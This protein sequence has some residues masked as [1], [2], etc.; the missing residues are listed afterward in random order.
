VC[1]AALGGSRP[2]SM[3]Q[4]HVSVDATRRC[5]SAASCLLCPADVY[6][7]ISPRALRYIPRSLLRPAAAHTEVC[8]DCKT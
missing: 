4:D 7:A 6:A 3:C 1:Q 5:M 8:E 2:L